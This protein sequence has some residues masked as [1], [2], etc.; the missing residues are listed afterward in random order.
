MHKGNQV[1]VHAAISSQPDWIDILEIVFSNA[2]SSERWFNHLMQGVTV[3]SS[4]EYR[5]RP[6]AID[7]CI[8][9][10][11]NSFTCPTWGTCCRHKHPC[12]LDAED[13]KS[14]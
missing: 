2:K 6:V 9:H 5:S 12:L 3:E 10:Q 13:R 8:E 7:P 11:F 1:T 4:C 14:Y